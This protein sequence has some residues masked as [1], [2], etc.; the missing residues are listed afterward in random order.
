MNMFQFPPIKNFTEQGIK[1]AFLKAEN[2]IRFY[3]IAVFYFSLNSGLL[4][5]LKFSSVTELDPLWPVSW[6]HFVDTSIAINIIF[7]AFIVGALLSTIFPHHRLARILAFLGLFEFVAF[8][9]SFGKINHGFHAWVLTS[10]LLIF[11][12]SLKYKLSLAP[13][14]YRKFLLVFWACQA[15][16]FLIYTMSGIAKIYSAFG[17]IARGEIHSFHPQALS[18]QIADRLL[19]T[20]STTLLGPWLIEHEILGWALYITSI[21]LELFAFYIV[22]RPSLH[23]L[24]ALGLICMHIGIYLALPVSFFDNVLLLALFF[25]QS[26]FSPPKMYWYTPLTDLPIFGLFIKRLVKL[27]TP[28]GR[29]SKY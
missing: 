25:F 28:Y 5:W 1:N 2:I 22:F 24:W 19:Q 11:L 9:N 26:P 15:I 21:F 12:P 23:K 14:Y 27:P 13:I 10:F 29:E 20:G 8:T 7:S 6:I 3:Y 16:V 18:L 4:T 17:Q